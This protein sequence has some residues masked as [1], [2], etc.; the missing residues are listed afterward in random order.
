MLCKV[1]VRRRNDRKKIWHARTV[2]IVVSQ[3]SSCFEFCVQ[4][5]KICLFCPRS[6]FFGP[7]FLPHLS[8]E[9]KPIIC[10]TEINCFQCSNKQHSKIQKLKSDLTFCCSNE[11]RN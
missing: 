8:I 4:P 7:P 2:A 10:S 1:G 9:L 3:K 5:R 6:V 11:K